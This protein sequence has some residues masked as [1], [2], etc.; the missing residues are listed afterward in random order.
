M[1]C[2]VALGMKRIP[3]G[4]P[5]WSQ[6]GSAHAMYVWSHEVA[7]GVATL[8]SCVLAMWTRRMQTLVRCQFKHQ[9]QLCLSRMRYPF[10]KRHL[11]WKWL[12]HLQPFQWPLLLRRH[13]TLVSPQGLSMAPSPTI[14]EDHPGD[15]SPRILRF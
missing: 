3:G 9:N 7:N 12:K 5:Q 6:R 14:P 2:T 4:C 13:V 8:S 1:H 15:H 10:W 11:S